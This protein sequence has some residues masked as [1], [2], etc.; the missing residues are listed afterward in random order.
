MLTPSIGFSATS[1]TI[2]GA[3]IPVVS[4]L[5]A[6]NPQRRAWETYLQTLP[7]IIPAV[8]GRKPSSTAWTSATPLASGHWNTSAIGAV[9]AHR[10]VSASR[11]V[12]GG[13]VVGK[14]VGGLAGPL[15][16]ELRVLE[17]VR[18]ARRAAAT[19]ARDL[20]AKD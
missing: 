4:R 16:G 5:P 6:Q 9:W 20:A 7:W 15:E 1:L 8:P 10:R 2:V 18:Q 19:R 11:K 17:A 14:T 13:A 3:T 12:P